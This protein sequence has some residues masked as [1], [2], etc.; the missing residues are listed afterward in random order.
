MRRF[1]PYYRVASFVGDHPKIATPVSKPDPDPVNTLRGD[2][3]VAQVCLNCTRKKCS[4][5]E[6]CFRKMRKEQEAKK[7]EPA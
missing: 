3:D 5:E 1:I 6:E 4:G 2:Y 7:V